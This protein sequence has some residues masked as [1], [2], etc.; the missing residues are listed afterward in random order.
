[1]SAF[2]HCARERELLLITNLEFRCFFW[3]LC[4]NDEITTNL[5]HRASIRHALASLPK[6]VYDKVFD[7]LLFH[8]SR[9][10]PQ[11]NKTGLTDPA[12]AV[13]RS[14]FMF[15]CIVLNR[16]LNFLLL[17]L[18]IEKRSI[19]WPRLIL[20]WINWFR[21]AVWCSPGL[22]EI[23]VWAHT[24]HGGFWL[25]ICQLRK[26][27]V[28]ETTQNSGWAMCFLVPG[29]LRYLLTWPVFEGLVGAVGPKFGLEFVFGWE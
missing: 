27:W 23:S 4:S 11:T 9:H 10:L 29:M 22:R 3:T 19:T 5:L 8:R 14:E 6:A 25:Q 20:S 17:L 7:V 21:I 16:M 15:C 1:M 2:E 24:L 13:P 26:I 12:D 18:F 28:A